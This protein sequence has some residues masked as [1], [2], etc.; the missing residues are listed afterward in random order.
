MVV[1]GLPYIFTFLVFLF[2][3]RLVPDA[4]TPWTDIWSG[5]LIGSLL[6]EL[7]KHAFTWYVTTLSRYHLFWGSVGT[8]IVLLLWIYFSASM[9]LFGA[10]VASTN[11][12]VREG[13]ID[14]DAAIIEGANGF[15]N[16]DWRG[17]QNKKQ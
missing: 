16:R 17:E 8:V 11:C 4:K 7:G 14:L 6:F 5:A 15:L 10:E 3:Y 12:K 1:M 9:L 13:K 2:A